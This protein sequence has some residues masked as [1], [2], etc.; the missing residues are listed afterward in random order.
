M[1]T[2]ASAALDAF[3]GWLAYDCRLSNL[4]EIW[5]WDGQMA[6]YYQAIGR[7]SGSHVSRDSAHTP[8]IVE[9]IINERLNTRHDGD[10]VWLQTAVPSWFNG[11]TYDEN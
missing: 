9:E 8:A 2:E 1:N 5:I 11:H 6:R 7:P 10:A 4:H 3:C